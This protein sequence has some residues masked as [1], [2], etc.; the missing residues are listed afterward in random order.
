M[1]LYKVT[2]VKWPFNQAILFCSLSGYFLLHFIISLHLMNASME[3]LLHGYSE[4][5]MDENGFSFLES[6]G[7]KPEAKVDDCSAE[8]SGFVAAGAMQPL[9][10]PQSGHRECNNKKSNDVPFFDFSVS[11]DHVCR[12]AKLDTFDTP[13]KLFEPTSINSNDSASS[14]KSCANICNMDISIFAKN[15]EPEKP[16]EICLNNVAQEIL[17]AADEKYALDIE[18]FEKSANIARDG[19]KV[20]TMKSNESF[21]H[22]E[23]VILHSTSHDMHGI[24]QRIS[25]KAVE[26]IKVSVR[27]LKSFGPIENL[28]VGSFKHMP[29]HETLHR[30][31]EETQKCISE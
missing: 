3:E 8:R 14:Q 16:Q 19:A 2:F 31:L 18:R 29:L 20:F 27:E 28:L 25:A 21:E 13:S 1:V 12:R 15:R 22:S 7:P 17:T 4:R 10:A 26:S 23:N 9:F 6:G 11:K 24:L 30:I 5:K